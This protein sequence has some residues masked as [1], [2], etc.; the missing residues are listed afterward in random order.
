MARHIEY[1]IHTYRKNIIFL[2]LCSKYMTYIFKTEFTLFNE[3]LKATYSGSLTSLITKS[4]SKHY[5]TTKLDHSL[6]KLQANTC[7]ICKQE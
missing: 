5:E 7:L 2:L 1:I 3:I 4:R 6:L